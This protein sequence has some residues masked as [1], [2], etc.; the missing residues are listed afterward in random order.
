[1]S[2]AE[3]TRMLACS[4]ITKEQVRVLVKTTG[5]RFTEK[6]FVDKYMQY[7]IDQELKLMELNN[8]TEGIHDGTKPDQ[9]G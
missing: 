9:I 3:T 7:G 2:Y 5:F 6:Q 4:S 8:F 1:M